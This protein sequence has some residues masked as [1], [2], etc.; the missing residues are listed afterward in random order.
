MTDTQED[1]AEYE[2]IL[3]TNRYYTDYRVQELQD[4]YQEDYDLFCKFLSTY[5]IT[6][7]NVKTGKFDEDQTQPPAAM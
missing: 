4:T 5:G 7:V 1:I 2:E 6:S 3:S